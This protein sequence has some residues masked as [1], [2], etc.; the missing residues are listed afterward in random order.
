[1]MYDILGTIQ[2]LLKG[3]G[4]YERVHMDRTKSSRQKQHIR[5]VVGS[6]GS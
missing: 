4:D 2:G 6:P 1:M 5:Y 3:L